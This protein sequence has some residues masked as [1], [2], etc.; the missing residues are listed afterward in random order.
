V[1]VERQHAHILALRS[2]DKRDY[3]KHRQVEDP[4]HVLGPVQP[5]IEV[6]EEEH[7]RDAAII[8]STIAIIRF[9]CRSGL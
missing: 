9:F 3:A 7:Q 5:V 2:L 1:E 6:F 8:P 4:L